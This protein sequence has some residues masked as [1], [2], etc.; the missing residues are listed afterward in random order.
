MVG[1]TLVAFL[2]GLH[3][4]WPKMT[5]R[6]YSEAWARVACFFDFRGLQHRPFPAVPPRQ[7]GYAPRA[8]TSTPECS[9]KHPDFQFLHRA[10]L[11]RLFPAG[12]RAGP[13]ALFYL[14]RSLWN[15]ETGAGQPLGRSHAGMAVQLAAAIRQFPVAPGRGRSLQ[16]PERP[17]RSVRRRLCPR[18]LKIVSIEKANPERHESPKEKG[19]VGGI[20]MSLPRRGS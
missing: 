2:A 3:Y 9:R 1:G 14:L 10:L 7:P 4:W 12:D 20:V 19:F 13:D 18:D 11:R 15:G 17:V 16:R 5:G 6:M 8:I